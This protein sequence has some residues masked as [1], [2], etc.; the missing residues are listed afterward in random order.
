MDLSVVGTEEIIGGIMVIIASIYGVHKK[1]K[2]DIVELTNQ[3]AEINVIETLIKQRDDAIIISDSYREKLILNETDLR[4][5]HIKINQIE[6]EKLK[7][8]EH[9]DMLEAESSILRDIIDYLTDT[10]SITRKTIEKAD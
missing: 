6:L 4:V 7:L 2:S 5:L 9:V 3:K 1:L 8:L 10:V